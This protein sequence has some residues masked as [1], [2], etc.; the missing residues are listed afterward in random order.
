[1]AAATDNDKQTEAHC[2]L[3]YR[4]LR[5]GDRATARELFAWVRDRGNPAL[6]EYTM[7]VAELDKH[8]HA[9]KE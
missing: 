4:R 2:F 8:D 3:G 1:M 9:T 7:S 5:D 6:T